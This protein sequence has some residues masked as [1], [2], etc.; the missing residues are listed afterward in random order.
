MSVYISGPHLPP[1]SGHQSGGEVPVICGVAP[2]GLH[3]SVHPVTLALVDE[4]D[5]HPN[6][7]S[8]PEGYRHAKL[9]GLFVGQCHRSLVGFLVLDSGASW[10]LK[11][12]SVYYNSYQWYNQSVMGSCISP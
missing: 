12:A 1:E 2:V 6:V 4:C 7:T 5:N 3:P 11:C 10:D 8:P 9:V